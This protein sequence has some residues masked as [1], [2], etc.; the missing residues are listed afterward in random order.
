[1]NETFRFDTSNEFLAALKKHIDLLLTFS[2]GG[3]K[4]VGCEFL[5]YPTPTVPEVFLGLL[6]MLAATA[7]GGGAPTL[8]SLCGLLGIEP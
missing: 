5:G 7:V 6:G 3:P 1:M 2:I 4:V 8:V